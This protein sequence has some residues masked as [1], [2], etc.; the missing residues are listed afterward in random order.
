DIFDQKLISSSSYRYRLSMVLSDVACTYLIYDDDRWLCYKSYALEAHNR[1]LFSLK[2]ELELLLGTDKML[3]L[4]FNSVHIRILT[5]ACTQ[6]PTALFYEEN[7]YTY[8]NSVCASP[9]TEIVKTDRCPEDIVSIYLVKL[10][11][12]QYLQ[13]LWPHATI[14]NL[15]SD[16]ISKYYQQAKNNEGNAM[17]VNFHQNQMQV[18]VFQQSKLLLVN[19]YDFQTADDVA[20]F[21]MLVINQLELHSETIA[22]SLSGHIN[23]KAELYNTIYRYVRNVSFMETNTPL[24][25]HKEHIFGTYAVHTFFDII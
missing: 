18:L 25:Y 19:N 7:A 24:L 11:L 17:Y 22:L 20:Y 16:L 12:H 10:D 8:L 23:A 13:K 21:T 5:P 3:N 4:S 9:A 2:D 15:F 14:T 1:D 6:V